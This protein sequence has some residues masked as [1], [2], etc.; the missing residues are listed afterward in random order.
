MIQYQENARTNIQ[1]G[2]I[3]EDIFIII[4]IINT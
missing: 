1:T 2:P 3:E 4:D